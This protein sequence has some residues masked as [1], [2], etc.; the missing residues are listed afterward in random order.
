MNQERVQSCIDACLACARECDSCATACL[1]E[2]DITMLARC[3]ELDRECA[4]ACYATA[5]LMG[6]GGEHYALF[7]HACAEICEACAEECEKHVEHGMD[8]CKAC[9]EAC[10]KCADECRAMVGVNA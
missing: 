10:R 1:N 2:E 4:E 6:M 9:A 3:I 8:H 5:R 7:C